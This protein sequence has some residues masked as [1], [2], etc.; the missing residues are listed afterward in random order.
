VEQ[1]GDIRERLLRWLSAHIEPIVVGWDQDGGGWAFGIID[2]DPSWQ[3]SRKDTRHRK[4]ISAH[5]LKER[6]DRLIGR[7]F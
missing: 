7:W 6:R 1:I 3:Y 4:V 2:S 5:A